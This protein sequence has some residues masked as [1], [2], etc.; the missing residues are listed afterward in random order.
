MIS[1]VLFL[2]HTGRVMVEISYFSV[3]PILRLFQVIQRAHN[4]YLTKACLT[5]ALEF[6]PPLTILT[7][8]GGR[9]YE[10]W[11]RLT[12]QTPYNPWPGLG[13]HFRLSIRNKN[14]IPSTLTPLI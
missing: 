3:H 5:H 1:L 11:R 2:T 10:A 6:I 12:V 13:L 4:Q 7:R 9:S 14:F 8:G